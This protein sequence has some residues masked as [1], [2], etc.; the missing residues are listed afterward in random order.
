[1]I[2]LIMLVAKGLKVCTFYLQ[3]ELLSS[4]NLGLGI[5]LEI[6]RGKN[7]TRPNS[8]AKQVREIEWGHLTLDSMTF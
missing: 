5:K 8:W 1:M 2:I 7:K 3:I 4:I 6:K